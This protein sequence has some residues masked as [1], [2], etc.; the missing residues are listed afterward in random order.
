MAHASLANRESM[1]TGNF[2]HL[3]E[4]DD[5]NFYPHGHVPILDADLFDDEFE[6]DGVSDFMRQFGST[7]QYADL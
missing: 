7:G 2:D 4:A 1:S 6:P 5:G 3:L